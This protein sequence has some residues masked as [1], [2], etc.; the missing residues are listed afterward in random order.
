MRYLLLTLVVAPL[1]GCD[2]HT[3]AL[4]ACSDELAATVS[5]KDRSFPDGAHQVDVTA[6]GVA[7]SCA[8]TFAGAAVAPAC[9]PGLSLSVVPAPNCIEA[10]TTD[11][12]SRECFDP[13]P[14]QF[15][16]QISLRGTPAELRVVQVVDGVA[17]LDQ[18]LMAVYRTVYPNGDACPGACKLA[19]PSFTLQ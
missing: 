15:V 5:R 11:S 17:L 1:A 4:R 10:F 13:I 6:D 3:C 7:L 12:V 19:T 18:S 14:G 8:F 2:S 9:S 16:E